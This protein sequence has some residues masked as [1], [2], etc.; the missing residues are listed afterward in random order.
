MTKRI[1]SPVSV[2]IQVNYGYWLVPE[3]YSAIIYWAKRM[4][5]S[6]IKICQCYSSEHIPVWGHSIKYKL[7]YTVY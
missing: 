3:T 1:S 2:N 6:S 4:N 7:P 5:D